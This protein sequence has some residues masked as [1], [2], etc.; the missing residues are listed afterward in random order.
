MTERLQKLI[1]QAGITSRR[2]AERLIADGHVTING[3]IATLGDKGDPN[4]DDIRVDGQRLK[5]DERMRYIILNKGRGVVSS[6][7][8]QGDRKTVLDFVDVPERLYPVGRLDIDSDGLILLTNDGDLT[9]KLTHPRY[10]CEKTYK[11]KVQGTPSPNKLERWREGIRLD[12]QRTAPCVI[13]VLKTGRQTELRIVMREGKKRQIRRIA[14]RLGHPVVKLTRT[15]IGS[16]ALGDLKPN[17]TR[18]LT[19]AEVEELKNSAKPP[20]KS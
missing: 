18:E 15:H 11:V 12:G 19:A 10:G 17:Q 16:V 9:N 7:Q 3:N 4:T 1:A 2:D 13:K 6:T 8:S 14:E 5:L 20:I